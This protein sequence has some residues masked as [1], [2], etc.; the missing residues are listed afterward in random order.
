MRARDPD[1]TCPP[2]W[3]IEHVGRHHPTCS[4]RT[5]A[6]SLKKPLSIQEVRSIISDPATTITM[7]SQDAVSELRPYV[8]RV[9]VAVR[10]VCSRVGD[11]VWVSDQSCLTDFFDHPRDRSQDQLLYDRIGGELGISLDRASESE[12]DHFVVRI[13]ARLRLRDGLA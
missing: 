1:C 7:A 11:D 8:D 6:V 13:A 2:M 12:D 10:G 3:P 9:L 4:E 5:T